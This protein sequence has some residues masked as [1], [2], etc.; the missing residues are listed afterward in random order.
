MTKGGETNGWGEKDREGEMGGLWGR[1]EDRNKKG[2]AFRGHRLNLET[3]TVIDWQT[4]V[5]Y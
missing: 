5:P 1:N 2:C 4:N 3:L